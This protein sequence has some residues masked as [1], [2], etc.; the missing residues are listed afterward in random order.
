MPKIRSHSG[1]KKRFFVTKRGKVK[2]KVSGQRHLLIGDSP[3]K[4]RKARKM[5]ILNGTETKM[6]K[7]LIPYA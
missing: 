6:I 5:V 2:Y 3:N 7:K 1:A 4:G